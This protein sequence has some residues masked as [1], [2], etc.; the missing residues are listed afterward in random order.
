[1]QTQYNDKRVEQKNKLI[2]QLSKRK[3]GHYKKYK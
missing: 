3:T 2:K 1:M